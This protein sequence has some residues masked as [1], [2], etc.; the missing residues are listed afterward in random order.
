MN[1]LSKVTNQTEEPANTLNGDLERIES[2]DGNIQVQEMK[3]PDTTRYIMNAEIRRL[4]LHYLETA[5][6]VYILSVLG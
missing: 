1:E 6:K 3:I 2:T 5:Q 4:F